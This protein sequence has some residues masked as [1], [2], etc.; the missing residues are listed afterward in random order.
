MN[1][2]PQWVALL[3]QRRMLIIFML[4]ISS[5]LPLALSANTLQVWLA[6]AGV[7]IVTLG[8]LS[9]VGQPYAYKF[10]WAPLLDKY[11]L[12]FLGLRRGWIISLQVLIALIL[13]LMGM[14]NP[15]NSAL[16]LIY[17]AVCLVIASATQDIVIDAYRVELLAAD[18][19]GMGASLSVG[20]YRIAMILSGGLGLVIA[21]YVGF[22][23][24]Y[25]IMAGAMLIGTIAVLF[26]PEP[27]HPTIKNNTSLMNIFVLPFKEFLSRENAINLL[28]L[29]I[30][31]KLGDA[32]AQSLVSTF[33][34]TGVGF[35]KLEIGGVYKS[36]GL[37]ATLFG[38]FVG[39]AWMVKLGLFRSLLY[40][41]ILQALTNLLF[42]AL[43]KV[44]PHLGL[45]VTTVFLENFA[46]GLGTAAYLALLM[47]LCNVRFTAAQFALLS[48]LSA[49]GRIYV[50]PG[51]AYLVEIFGWATFFI[52]STV[53]ALPGLILLL[54]IKKTI[55]MYGDRKDEDYMQSGIDEAKA[56]A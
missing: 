6:E 10:F 9:L 54:K 43:A 56:E 20:G 25:F 8:L 13:V 28:A 22:H 36:F 19:K 33:L 41:G 7:G 21:H 17:L 1:M 42:Y 31:Y 11:R 35:T 15:S 12:P 39:G 4:G 24:L 51:S 52:F 27:A 48:A 45:L 44:G 37:A 34:L 2:L 50:G 32:F 53:F 3:L 29:I 47:S 23:I 49:V 30:L 55:Q 14:Q 40:F 18:E 26:G 16:Q 5:G 38:V 46:G